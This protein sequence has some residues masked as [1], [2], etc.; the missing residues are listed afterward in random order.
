MTEGYELNLRDYWSI[1]LKR[2]GIILLSFFAV[3]IS[4]VAYTNFQPTLYK[5]SAIIKIDPTVGLSRNVFPERY[6]WQPSELPDYAKQVVSLPIIEKAVNELDKNKYTYEREE[7]NFIFNIA[8]NISAQEMEKTNMIKVTM[9]SKNP[10]FSAE[11][12]NKIIDVFKEE[13][14]K[15]KNQ[16]VRNVREFIGEQ[17]KRVSVQLKH[18]EDRLNELTLRGVG[19]Q[20]NLITDKI[21]ELE[22]KRSDLLAQS[23]ETDSIEKSLEEVSAKTTTSRGRLDE[24][25][26]KGIGNKQTLIADKI[27][28]LE[29]KRSDLL[30][31]YTPLYPD[32]L[33][34]DEQLISLREQ[35]N[36][37]PEEEFEFSRLSREIEINEKLYNSLRGKLQEAKLK[38]SE[39]NN[40]I[41]KIDE[42][43]IFSKTQLENLPEEEFEFS[44]LKRDVAINEKLYNSLREKLQEAQIKESEKI[45]NV[46]LVTPAIPPSHPFSPNKSNNYLI[47]IILGMILAISLG[48]ISEH[49]D[50]SIGKIEDLESITDINVIGV[51][52]Y[53]IE[54]E[55]D[56]KDIHKKRKGFIGRRIR[57]DD[58][59]DSKEHEKRRFS[60]WRKV[61]KEDLADGRSVKF[62]RGKLGRKIY[63]RADDYPG[64]KAY[65]KRK[66][67]FKR[68]VRGG[69]GVKPLR[70]E[71]I[72]KHKENSVFLEAFR[73]L[74]ANIQVIF[75][76]G[77]RIKN[78]CML[79]TSS[80]PEEGKSIVA[81]NLSII[82]AQMG[83]RTVLID[84]DLR[85]SS[86][87]KIFGL[88]KK[89]KGVTDILT[90]E[91][92][93]DSAKRTITDILLGRMDQD[94]LLKNPWIANLH[95][96][97]SGTTF[98]NSPYLLNTEK[99]D[100]F[101][102]DLKTKYE[103]IIMDSTPVLAVSD[104]SIIVSKVD[105]VLLV[106]RAGFTSRISLRRAK[107]QM[108]TA[109]KEKIIKG[110]ILNN[111]T[112]EIS[113]D[114]YYYYYQGKYYEDYQR[115]KER[116]RGNI[117]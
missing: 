44:T 77:D 89:E 22:S 15:Q 112:P 66:L 32:V 107:I 27:A 116:K 47:G 18:S 110:I 67:N 51:I 88:E 103:V 17:L 81:S 10:D 106:Y 12:I 65:K 5:A 82:M 86:I 73:I 4:T 84:A 20:A 111:V 25:A 43:I 97:T 78:K 87:H 31:K 6:Y 109:R 80:N 102:G 16:Q 9:V 60:P 59:L 41:R 105:G 55:K 50:T 21:A 33:K 104:P 99:M 48:L 90:G 11:I 46:I 56:I 85:R 98:P 2:R 74:G 100:L 70:D 13:N 69:N 1:F 68:R 93:L 91:I 19:G 53:F 62:V 36:D 8:N 30:T 101:I 35:I 61:R 24:L 75:G 79:I 57:R 113:T 114:T 72:L 49:L 58:N 14:I 38:E 76:E 94:Y 29:S 39:K 71:L 45:D 34:I 26:L 63:V 115:E 117:P 108:E 23:N 37:L 28:E 40:N 95:I 3:I 64:T 96:I 7:G 83:Y 54:R 52:P 92:T 42:Q